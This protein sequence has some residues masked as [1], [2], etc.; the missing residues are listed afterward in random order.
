MQFQAMITKSD[1]VPFAAIGLT[2]LV[3]SVGYVWIFPGNHWPEIIG[4][5]IGGVFVA[6]AQRRQKMFDEK[7]A[8]RARESED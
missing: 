2:V 6:I 1:I 7:R 8:Q 4:V 5:S 3:V